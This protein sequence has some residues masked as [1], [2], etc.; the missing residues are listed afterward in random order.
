MDPKLIDPLAI[1][2]AQK[3]HRKWGVYASVTIAQYGQESGWGKHAPGNNPFGIKARPGEDFR[4]ETTIEVIHGVAHQVVAN[5]RVF[6]SLDEAFDAHGGLIATAPCYGPAMARAVMGDLEGFI[7]E[8]AKHYATDTLYAS[9][10]MAI[11][12]GDRLTQFDAS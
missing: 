1:Q 2:A 12:L 6:P 11:I 4:A 5:F 9:H 10:L 3:A 8:M 7:T